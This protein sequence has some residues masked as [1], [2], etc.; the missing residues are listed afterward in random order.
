MSPPFYCINSS[1]GDFLGVWTLLVEGGSSRERLVAILEDGRVCLTRAAEPGRCVRR[2]PLLRMYLRFVSGAANGVPS[3]RRHAFA[4]CFVVIPYP[5]SSGG[6]FFRSVCVTPSAPACYG[7]TYFP[8]INRELW[9]SQRFRL[10]RLSFATC[11]RQRPTRMTSSWHKPGQKFRTIVV[12][13]CDLD[14][15][16]KLICP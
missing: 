4:P 6:W 3:G 13:L 2:H 11:V 15:V 9:N 16:V 14:S 1:R 12:A 7:G 8:S 10:R 5:T